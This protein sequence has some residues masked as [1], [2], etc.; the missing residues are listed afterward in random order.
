ME[1]QRCLLDLPNEILRDKIL[2]YIPVDDLFWSIGLVCQRLMFL[3]FDICKIIRISHLNEMGT[4]ILREKLKIVFLYK[5][6][7]ENVTSFKMN[8]TYRYKPRDTD[9]IIVDLGRD[10]VPLEIVADTLTNS[11]ANLEEI[12]IDITID[13]LTQWIELGKISARRGRTSMPL[14]RRR[15]DLELKSEKSINAVGQLATR[16][17]NLRSL[18]ITILGSTSSE[19]FRLLAANIG[20]F[21]ELTA[22]SIGCKEIRTAYEH[23]YKYCKYYTKIGTQQILIAV[24]KSCPYLQEI[25]LLGLCAIDIDGLQIIADNCTN[26]KVFIFEECDFFL[27]MVLLG[28][29]A[30][31]PRTYNIKQHYRPSFM[32]A[33]NSAA[34]ITVVSSSNSNSNCLT[35]AESFQTVVHEYKQLLN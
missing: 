35:L 27:E 22:I 24:C 13:K 11:C 21:K 34:P 15:L 17:S 7:A 16:F 23:S 31:P 8:N 12:S 6:I 2:S 32:F 14:K 18:E 9:G 4:D 29:T 19:E 1:E 5:E 20:C 28:I 25:L 26:L 10:N 3:V 30:S 33:N